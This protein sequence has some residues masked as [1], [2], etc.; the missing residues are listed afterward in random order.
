MPH[1]A[2]QQITLSSSQGQQKHPPQAEGSLE[3]DPSVQGRYFGLWQT[4]WPSGYD[5]IST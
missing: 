2:M 1:G 4:F 5:P 3:E